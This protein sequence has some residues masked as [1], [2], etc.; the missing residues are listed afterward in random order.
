MSSPLL[1]DS[2]SRDRWREAQTWEAAH[3]VRT[4]QMR[5]RF[6]KNLIWKVLSKF[7]VFPKY[8]GDDWN[9]WW[10]GAFDD[11]SFLPDIVPNAI[12]VGCGP[13]TNTRLMLD[14]CKIEHLVLSDPLIRTYI[15]FKLT[16]VSEMH[17]S[18]NCILDDH[19][20]ENL[21]FR[22]EFFDLAVMINVLDHVQDAGQCMQSLLRITKPGGIVILGQDLSDEKDV[23]RM[24][25]G[26]GE[27]GHPIK[28]DHEWFESYLAE[29]FETI[30]YR[31]LDQ[32]R[33]RSP[34]IHY[35]TL[36]FAGR[37]TPKTAA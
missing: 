30:L 10:K 15:N 27:I 8:R 4:Q 17:R 7:G 21:P 5:S 3:W 28:L 11:Y 2:V 20:L 22:D 9:L 32:E 14:K 6:G 29:G 23:K 33:G 25:G 37:K 24:N 18:G 35:G 13:Y 34:G 26:E 19:P 36:I 1:V 31:V 16:F 12:E